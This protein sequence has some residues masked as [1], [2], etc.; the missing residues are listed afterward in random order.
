[1]GGG[2]HLHPHWTRLPLPLGRRG[3]L[4]PPRSQLVHGD[5]P[6]DGPRTSGAYST[7]N[8]GGAMYYYDQ[9]GNRTPEPFREK[10]KFT[11]RCCD[12]RLNS[13]S[14]P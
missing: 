5:A 14:V 2:Y 6:E 8:L 7:Q 12:D 4:E 1:V 3:R 9:A 10:I 13:D 11:Q